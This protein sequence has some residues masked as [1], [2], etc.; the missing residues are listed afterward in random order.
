[1]NI[2]RATFTQL[3]NGANIFQMLMDF[4]P[5]IFRTIINLKC[6]RTKLYQCDQ[7]S[8][9]YLLIIS[10][11]NDHDLQMLG[12][13][14][15]F[16]RG[17]NILF[18]F[19]EALNTVINAQ[20][21]GFYPKFENDERQS[22]CSVG[23]LA[24]IEEIHVT[25]KYSGFLGSL[26]AFIYKSHIY[27][28]LTSKNATTN[29]Y[30]TYAQEIIEK[31][32][33]LPAVVNDLVTTGRYLYGEV[34]SHHNQTHGARVLN[35]AFMVTC[36][37]KTLS[38]TQPPLSQHLDHMAVT[39]FCHQYQLPCDDVVIVKG[40]ET[41]NEFMNK[42]NIHRDHMTHTQYTC[43]IKEASANVQIIGGTCS[44]ANILGD[45][46]E[47]LVI[48]SPTKIFK[49]KF[50]TYTVRTM[51]LRPYVEKKIVGSLSDTI[52]DYLT[53]WV[54]SEEGR[55]YWRGFITQAIPL[56]NTIPQDPLVG[57][58]IVV[59]D[60]VS[61]IPINPL[62]APSYQPSSPG[63][64]IVILG[65]V[66]VGKTTFANALA[67]AI[68]AVHIDGDQLGLTSAEVSK[69]GDERSPYTQWKIVETL[70]CGHIPIISC[71]GGVLFTFK[72][73]N[74]ICEL[75][76][77]IRAMTGISVNVVLFLP[78][79]E[80]TTIQLVD[81]KIVNLEIYND[82]SITMQAISRRLSAGE[83]T[84]PKGQKLDTY[85]D[86][87]CEISIKNKL[88]AHKM[89][90]LATVVGTYPVIRDGVAPAMSQEFLGTMQSHLHQPV[91]VP[92]IYLKQFRLLVKT[93]APDLPTQLKQQFGGDVDIGHITYKFHQEGMMYPVT[94]LTE[95]AQLR[96]I[97]QGLLVE[98]NE[99]DAI[100]KPKRLLVATPV[101]D[102]LLSLCEHGLTHITVAPGNHP[103]VLMREVI[104]AFRAS[105]SVTLRAN[106][107]SSI[108]YEIKCAHPCTL[109]V[110]GVFTIYI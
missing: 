86:K 48:F 34:I 41:I 37:G 72:Q 15:G 44:H 110:I 87:I 53:R 6:I 3:T 45:I 74:H 79:I 4:F 56:F 30:V 17:F 84:V 10:G 52:E 61:T 77:N 90:E 20:S 24:G 9:H 57:H 97:Y 108:T 16:P 39:A 23:E 83:W 55:R 2:L 92:S 109:E 38:V 5:E 75:E 76:K 82:Q 78:S 18:E 51:L 66:G 28:Y 47:G 85:I 103:P 91:P 27:Y 100:K 33:Q 71:G 98:A 14:Y 107:G 25:K 68:G 81:K 21:H 104:K 65:P 95:L 19:N 106:D 26:C 36:I 46:L 60:Y 50:A 105:T 49:Y 29:E 96:G 40:G 63:T 7:T 35:D 102:P 67:P 101:S 32:P 93:I 1:M 99:I 42:L 69:L 13:T 58:H 54:I 12:R 11:T 80:Q 88:F 43:L 31:L 64:V 89:L 73:Q 70:I 62:N 94:K 8:V 22:V 59:S